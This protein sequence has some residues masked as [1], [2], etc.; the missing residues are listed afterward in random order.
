MTPAWRSSLALSRSP[1]YVTAVQWQAQ[2]RSL[3]AA[4]AGARPWLA[5]T[6]A[7]A[8]TRPAFRRGYA[9]AAEVASTESAASGTPAPKPPRRKAG[10]FRWIYRLTVLS[11]LAGSTALGYSIWLYRHPVEQ[12]PPDPNKKTLVVLGECRRWRVLPRPGPS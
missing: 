11:A 9:D 10:F 5:T 3:A 4:G 1:R 8:T 2:H 6:T 7:A 12:L